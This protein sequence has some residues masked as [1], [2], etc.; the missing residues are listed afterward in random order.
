MIRA[1]TIYKI[2]CLHCGKCME[3]QY[4]DNITDDVKVSCCGCKKEFIFFQSQLIREFSNMKSIIKLKLFEKVTIFG[5]KAL[6]ILAIIVFI[7]I[8]IFWISEVREGR[9]WFIFRFPR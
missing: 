3:V 5:N 7:F 4:R 6:T 9:I 8:V 1:N 2:R